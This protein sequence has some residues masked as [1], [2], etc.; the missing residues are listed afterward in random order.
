MAVYWSGESGVPAKYTIFT[1]RT[2]SFTSVLMQVALRPRVDVP[3]KRPSS[4]EMPRLSSP[5]TPCRLS[6]TQPGPT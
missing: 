1:L 5:L 4:P 3:L 2:P 6:V